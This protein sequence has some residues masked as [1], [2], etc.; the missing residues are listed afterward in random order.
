[1]RF[2]KGF[3]GTLSG[4]QLFRVVDS[5][6]KI[7]FGDVL[8]DERIVGKTVDWLNENI[9]DEKEMSFDWAV[10]KAISELWT[11]DEIAYSN[12]DGEYVIHEKKPTDVTTTDIH[13]KISFDIRVDRQDLGCNRCVYI[14]REKK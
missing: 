14:I 9:K 7:P 5:E 1:M 8:A 11:P 6:N 13:N 4:E 2:K 12:I 3:V 10:E